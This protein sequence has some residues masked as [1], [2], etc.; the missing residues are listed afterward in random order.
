MSAASI[1]VGD[2]FGDDDGGR[3]VRRSIVSTEVSKIS[4]DLI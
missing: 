3:G 1:A 4:S 2:V